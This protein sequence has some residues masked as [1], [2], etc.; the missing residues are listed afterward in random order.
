[1]PRERARVLYKARFLMPTLP[2][3][4]IAMPVHNASAYL[5]EAIDSVLAQTYPHWELVCVDDASRDGSFQILQEY[6][7]RD[8]RIRPFAQP[9]HAGIVAARNRGAAVLLACLR[10]E[11]CEVRDIC[12]L[13]RTFVLTPVAFR[14][15]MPFLRSLGNIIERMCCPT[16]ACDPQRQSGDMAGGLARMR[17]A[18]SSHA[19]FSE[20]APRAYLERNSALNLSDKWVGTGKALDPNVIAAMLPDENRWINAQRAD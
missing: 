11:G 19:A 16:D 8:P 3:V 1:M 6:A 15:W 9:G 13:E 5:R 4:T 17:S 14:Y 18:H 12:N 7:A 2:R 20:V 10:V